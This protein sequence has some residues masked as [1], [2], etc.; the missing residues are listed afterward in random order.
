MKHK[1]MKR[2]L[3]K[4]SFFLTLSL[5]LPMYKHVHLVYENR[6]PFSLVSFTL[7]SLYVRFCVVLESHQRE[8]K[9]EFPKI[10]PAIFTLPIYM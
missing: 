6:A 4:F 5:T 1:F 9:T 7:I 10:K 8:V 3:D 2:G